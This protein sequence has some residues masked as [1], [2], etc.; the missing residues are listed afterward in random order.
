MSTN[1]NCRPSVSRGS[2]ILLTTSWGCA[3]SES[4]KQKKYSVRDALNKKVTE[5]LSK[6]VNE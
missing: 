1:V 3:T 6:Y 2:A 4:K 5:L